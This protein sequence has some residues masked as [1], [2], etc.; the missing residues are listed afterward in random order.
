MNILFVNDIPFNPQYGGI[1]RVTDVLTKELIAEYGHHVYYLSMNSITKLDYNYPAPI[2]AMPDGVDLEG[3]R[4]FVKSLVERFEIDIIVNQRGQFSH[5]SS[6]VEVEG[7]K[8]INVV[9]SLPTA[10]IIASTL[11]YFSLNGNSIR[12]KVKCVIKHLLYPFFYF[13][14]KREMSRIYA[15]QYRYILEHNHAT[16][17]LSSKYIEE[18]AKLLKQDLSNYNIVGI[19]NPNTFKDVEYRPHLKKKEILYVGRFDRIEKS[20]IRLIKIWEKIYRHHPEWTLVMVGGGDYE[21]V[22]H[23]YIKRR[24]VDRVRFEGVQTN[25][26]L[27]YERASF[28]CLTSNFEGWGMALT[29]GMQYGCIPFTFN[30]YG[31][32]SDIIDDNVSGC[33]IRPFDLGEYSAQLSKLMTNDNLRKEMSY[34]AFLKAKEFD[35]TN[36]VK[37][38][39]EMLR[40]LYDNSKH[41]CSQK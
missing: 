16:V 34:A 37:K 21:N 24:G 28:I 10:W 20:P 23:D 36:V 14:V 32:A 17:L 27:Y 12:A 3:K 8:I 41:A 26:S 30:N 4:Q 6:A 29:E 39:D 33:L 40:K 9:H 18:I 7:V 1:E 25:V 35:V 31:A 11:Y 5:I 2:Y 13:K 38:W 22:M 15:N 19:P